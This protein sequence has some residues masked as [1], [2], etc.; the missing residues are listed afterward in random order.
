MSVGQELLDIPFD[1]MIHNMAVAIA[2][3]QLAQDRS[4]IKTLQQLST[5]TTDV[6]TSVTE[7]IEPDPQSVNVPGSGTIPYT[8]AKVR[9]SGVQTVPMTLLQAGLTPT[10]YQFTEANIE[11]KL[12]IT[13]KKTAEA[14]TDGKGNVIP[15]KTRAFASAVNFRTA[16]T[17][18]YEANG[19]SCLKATIKPVPPPPRLT[20]RT[21]TVNALANPPVVSINNQ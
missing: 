4:A 18:S 14:T 16:A 3:G 15:A 5:E 17:Y 2:D 13:M 21:V 1:E 6:I 7:I 10:F 20:P 8:G 11:V 9:A 12:S 19:S